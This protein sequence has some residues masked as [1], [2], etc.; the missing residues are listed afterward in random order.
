MLLKRVE[1]MNY[2]GLR[3]PDTNVHVKSV[4]H[5]IGTIHRMRPTRR[6][7]KLGN[8]IKLQAVQE[9]EAV[10]TSQPDQPDTSVVLPTASKRI[11]VFKA[12]RKSSVPVKEQG[13]SLGKL[14]FASPAWS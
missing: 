5:N 11:A 4:N 2:Q 14:L 1:R 10:S 13:R 8:A 7:A 12:Q 9:N 6:H 3:K